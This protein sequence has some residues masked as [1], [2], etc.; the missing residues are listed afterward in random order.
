VNVTVHLSL[1]PG[2]AGLAEFGQAIG[3]PLEPHERRIARAYFGSAREVAAILPRGNA[4]TTLAA[5][6]GVHHLCS[7]PG[8]MVTIGAASRDQARICFERMRGFAE[9]PALED[10]LVVRHLELRHEEGGGLL[11]VV[12]SDGPR[13]HGLSSTLYIGDEVWAWPPNGEL[14]EAMQ[15]GLIKRRDSKLLLISTA[16]QLDS[17][18]GRLRARALAQ[19]SA[20]RTGT[21]VEARGDLH[22]LE[23]SLPDD[24]DLDDL[25]AV[26]RC[27]PA[28][29]ITVP[30][31]RR[32]RAAVPETAFAQF[33]ACRW[34]VGE[35]SWL[36][37]GA[38]QACV[39]EPEFAD[40]EDVWIGVDVGGERSAT[41]VV[42]VNERLH[43]GCAIY[44]G[45][46]GVLEAVDH[47]RALAGRY[48]VRELVYDPW[49][50]GQAAQELEREGLLVVAFPQHDARMIPASARLHAAV[51]EQRL[52]L[53]NDPELAR[54]AS[55][56]IARHS[57][58]GWRIDK[59]NPRANID[60]VI[61]LA[62]AVERAEAKPEPV[63]L[64]GWI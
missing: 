30:D 18:L 43:V 4:K 5:K 57:R 10:M 46:G 48:N 63:E 27:N 22:W 54:H 14:L 39:G 28:P 20:K 49:R 51:V 31:L 11:R 1:R 59:P 45:D 64:L 29:W 23:W 26:K 7:T 15:T 53:P 44:H 38:W 8:A 61:A 52:N 58:R 60:A 19:S 47:V 9:H 32:Q 13:V 50:F 37:P 25:A 35:G 55:D 16:A 40:G 2:L 36:P 17:P 62:M 34:G 21:V 33:H 12:P 6:V 41:G 56:A 24:T 3:E 42:W